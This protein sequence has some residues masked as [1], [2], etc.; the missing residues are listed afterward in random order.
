MEK[1]AELAERFSTQ[2]L[3]SAAFFLKYYDWASGEFET[4]R[5]CLSH[6]SGV[7]GRFGRED[8]AENIAVRFNSLLE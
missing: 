2:L 1:G 7:A 5:N 6:I 8:I 3:D 4:C